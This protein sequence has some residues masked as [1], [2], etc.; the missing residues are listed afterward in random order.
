MNWIEAVDAMKRGHH[1]HR[2]SQ[3]QRKLIG[4]SDGVPIYECGTETTR[5]AAAWTDD[6]R[7]VLVFQGAGSKALFA[8]ETDDTEATD[9]EIAA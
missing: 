5:L 2:K 9:W 4:H 7:P 1:V 6:G 8:P 3:Q